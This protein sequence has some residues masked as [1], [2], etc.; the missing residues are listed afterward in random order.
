M[1][2]GAGVIGAPSGERHWG[3]VRDCE[4]TSLLDGVH[5]R[6]NKQHVTLKD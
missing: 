4:G 5:K 1:Y 3:Q 2:A 6:D